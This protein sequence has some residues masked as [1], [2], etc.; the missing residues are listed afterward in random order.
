[1]A[2]HAHHHGPNHKHG[3]GHSHAGHSHHVPTSD[4]AILWA[5]IVNLALTGAQ[6]GGGL[7][8]DSTALIAD[9]IHN[10]SDAL[11]LVL[12]FG[13]RRLA[14]RPATPD[15]SWGWAGPRWSPHSSI[16]WR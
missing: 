16:I 4:T 10:L 13:A 5:V 2:G 15:Y 12:A 9:G 1:M 8:A 14:R 3:H 6:I 7:V 11:A